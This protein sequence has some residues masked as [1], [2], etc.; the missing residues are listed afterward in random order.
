[1]ANRRKFFNPY[2]VV[3]VVEY[4]LVGSRGKSDLFLNK[5]SDVTES[6]DDD[7]IDGAGEAIPG[8][9]YICKD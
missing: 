8:E 7:P 9:P 2:R 1:M 3:R 4:N 6:F 5:L